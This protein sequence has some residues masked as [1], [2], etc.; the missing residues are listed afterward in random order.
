MAIN[1][2]NFLKT[3]LAGTMA[4]AATPLL[5]SCAGNPESKTATSGKTCCNSNAKLRLS[6]QEG[7]A[8]GETLAEK[9]DYMEKLGVE[10]FEPGG[11]GLKGR[12]KEIKDLLNDR[13]VKVSAICAG[14]QGFILS[15]DPAIRQQCMDTMK[16]II[17]AA[18]ELGSTGVIIVPAFN[19]QVPALPHTM[20]TRDFLCEQFNEMGTF[21]AQHGT[22]VIFEPLNRG[23][24]FYL[25]Q[26]ADAASICRDI[27]NPGVRCMGDFW[28]MTWE[29]TS[30][31]GA[32]LSG[33]QYLQHVHVAS[34]KRR[35]MPGED[36]DADNYVDGF[37]GLKMIGYNNYVS[38]EC[39]CQ[40]DREVVVPAAV[41]LLRKQWEEA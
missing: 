30:D 17:E 12:V 7:I 22:T 27:D 26:V 29:E 5:A 34:R 35:S 32:F 23:E 13:P 2:R 14:F 21:A 9:L 15:T 36:G 25:R 6:F 16:E 4:T 39:G 40:G 28:H 18:G 24:A 20:E 19:Q 38:F 10:G 33:G 37:R 8:P 41:E 3:T 1:R 11:W 31:M